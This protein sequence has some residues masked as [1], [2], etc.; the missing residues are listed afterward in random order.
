MYWNNCSDYHKAAKSYSL[1]L[2]TLFITSLIYI[3]RFYFKFRLWNPPPPRFVWKTAHSPCLLVCLNPESFVLGGK[4]LKRTYFFL[5]RPSKN[6]RRYLFILYQFS[7]MSLNLLQIFRRNN[8]PRKHFNPRPCRRKL[9]IS[10]I[11]CPD[12]F[13][14]EYTKDANHYI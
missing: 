3:W 5:E 11:Y 1:L 9:N 14:C 6:M 12:F 13:H 7:V 8:I 4:F 2:L 10:S